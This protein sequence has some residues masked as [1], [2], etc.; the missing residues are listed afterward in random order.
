[1]QLWHVCRFTSTVSRQVLTVACA[2][3]FLAVLN[4]GFN[5]E[6]SIPSPNVCLCMRTEHDTRCAT[7]CIKMGVKCRAFQYK[8]EV[9]KQLCE[10]SYISSAERFYPHSKS[11]HVPSRGVVPNSAYFCKYYFIS[12]SAHT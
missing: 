11:R 6:H 3:C 12:L 8:I 4:G 5:M 1:M 10:L 7:E 9:D 2:L